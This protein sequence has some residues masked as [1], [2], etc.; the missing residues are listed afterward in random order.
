M[1]SRFEERLTSVGFTTL[2][3]IQEAVAEPL[4][5]GQSIDALAPT[6]TGKTLAFTWPLLPELVPEDGEQLLILAPSQEL[7]M[8][9]TRVIRDWANVLS[10]KVL[11]LTG[12]ANIK[13]Q[14]DRLKKHPEILIGT[15]GRVSELIANGK[16]KLK[17]LRTLILDEAD[18]LLRDD[19]AN[20]IDL[21]WDAIDDD[22]VQ[23]TLFGATEVDQSTASGLFNRDFLR[24]DQRQVKIP[25]AIKHEFWPTARDQRQKRLRQL[26]TQKHFQAIVF[27][28]T[29]KQL[30]ITA[31]FLAHEHVAMATLVRGDSSTTRSKSLTNFRQGKAKFLLTTD[32]AAR[33]LDIPDLPAII[34]FDLPRDGETY[35]HRAGRTGRMGKAG[36]VISFGNDHDYRDLKKMVAV[37]IQSI[38]GNHVLPSKKTAIVAEK[39][40]PGKPTTLS[41]SSTSEKPR[42]NNKAT[43]RK[44]S[45]VTNVISRQERFDKEKRAKRKHRKNKGK[46]KHN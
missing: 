4:A 12:G 26:A 5:S 3:P 35:T 29:T 16:L 37:D 31:S 28:N 13:H 15:P 36:T 39:M 46:P 19:T 7:A 24:I 11:S 41:P 45:E 44:K 1:D 34:N 22:D 23:V 17:R 20:Q 25:T 21:I 33:G 32:V 9:T 40:A 42:T 18:E 2:T 27:F 30:K 14:L 43:Q 6:G 8:Q 38:S 10:L